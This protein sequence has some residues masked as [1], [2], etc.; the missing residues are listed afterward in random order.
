MNS[1]L[2][3]ASKPFSNRLLPWALTAIILFISVIGL[4]VV[5]RL[6]T[7]TRSQADATQLE[8]NK[9]RQ[10]E[11]ALL[12]NA[13]EVKSMLTPEQQ[14]AVPAAH[15]LVDRRKFLWSKLLSDLESSLPANVRVSRIAV[16]DVTV[17]GDQMIAELELALFA[18]TPD[19]INDMISAM[20]REGIF[21]PEVREQNLQKGRGESGTEYTLD[22]VYRPR[23][24]YA[25]E[26]VA[27]MTGQTEGSEVSSR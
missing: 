23:A 8:I 25:H 4:L 11:Q 19:T 24:G 26:N 20:Y 27:E 16:R 3:L 9:L 22:V 14:Q 7:V 18:K 17:Q 6:A 15:Q 5:I 1:N 13:D 12:K 21:Q 2:N 10:E